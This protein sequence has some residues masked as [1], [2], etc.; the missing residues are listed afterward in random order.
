MKNKELP[1]LLD[2]LEQK[3]I[4]LKSLIHCALEMFVPHPG[5]ETEEKA[6]E[7]LREEFLDVL[8]DVNVSILET[9]AFHAQEDAEKGLI[10][11]LTQERFSGRPGPVADEV[12]GIAIANYIG[13]TRAVFEYVR[14]DQA[15]P[16]IL[17]KLGSITNDAIG[18]LVAGVSSNVYTRATKNTQAK[19]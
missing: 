4:S 2:F 15:K 12:L 14:F 16:G 10:P 6:V 3:G 13:G 17:K 5:V 11:G 1:P 18:G 8:A 7:M 9:A 19:Q